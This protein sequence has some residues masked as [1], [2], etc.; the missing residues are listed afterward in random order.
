MQLAIW[1]RALIVSTAGNLGDIQMITD[2]LFYLPEAFT[3]VLS[4]YFEPQDAD[5]FRELLEEQ[6][7]AV[8]APDRRGEKRRRE[9]SQSGNGQFIRQRQPDGSLSCEYQLVLESGTMD[10]GSG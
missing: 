5:R 7:M 6:I 8:A 4:R 9:N 2:R 1:E 3:G 10:R